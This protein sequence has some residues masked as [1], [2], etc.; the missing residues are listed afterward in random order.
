MERHIPHRTRGSA[1]VIALI[2]ALVVVILAT[3]GTQLMVTTF[4]DV[5]QQAH[6]GAEVDNFA[7]AGL[8]DAISW[9]RRQQTQPVC[10]G[11]PPTRYAWVD[12]AFDPK[13]STN[14][15]QSDTIDSSI[16]IVRE[17]QLSDDGHLWGRYE[18]KRQTSTTVSPY[19]QN[20]VH[21]ITGERLFTGFNDGQGYV[22][23]ISSKGYI[24]Q[25]IKPSVAFNVAPNRVVATSRV[26]TEIRRISLQL[27]AECAYIVND[28]GTKAARTITLGNNGRINGGGH[29]GVGFYSYS[30]SSSNKPTQ[31]NPPYTISNSSVTGSP[32]AWIQIST[33]P[34]SNYVLGVS[35]TELK[36]MADYSV[37][38]VSALPSTLPD[39]S[40]IYVQGNATFDAS[41][42]LRSSGILFVNGN[43]TISADANCLY[44]GLIY[45]TGTATIY[46][47]S[48]ISGCVIAYNGLTLSRSNSSDVAEIDYDRGILDMVRQQ[49]CQY[50]EIKSAYR[51]FTG[52]SDY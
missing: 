18:V 35:T 21:D 52:I 14:T 44:S 13:T 41:R 11:Y 3:A 39:M 23:Y 29:Y 46:D 24:Y 51:I 31:S 9:F 20:A 30:G 45:V 38:S 5:K 26:S 43:L 28:D 8:A 42:P 7:R 22:W 17:Y 36:L 16:G 33:A 34:T 50:R 15:A 25:R 12:G 1:L 49:I 4:K 2:L 47:P 19:D 48:L 27:P 40:L 32:T 37:S 10:S 6:L